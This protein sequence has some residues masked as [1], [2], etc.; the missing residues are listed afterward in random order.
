MGENNP[1][2]AGMPIAA[3]LS[4]P[5]TCWKVLSGTL[6]CFAMCLIIVCIFAIFLVGRFIVYSCPSKIQPKISFL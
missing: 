6:L 4:F 3:L 2:P 5:V 1:F